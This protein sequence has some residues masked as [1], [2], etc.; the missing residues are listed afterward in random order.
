MPPRLARLL[1]IVAAVVLVIG[2]FALRGSL[3]GGDDEEG[4][5]TGSGSGAGSA[6]GT[7]PRE[8]DDGPFQVLCDVDL[9]DAACEALEGSALVDEVEVV[10]RGSVAGLLEG[11]GG[12]RWDA[13]LTLRANSITPIQALL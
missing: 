8:T 5:S 7:E 10:S 12:E 1:A 2:A 11:D 3:S 13:W 6:S 9:G 4:V